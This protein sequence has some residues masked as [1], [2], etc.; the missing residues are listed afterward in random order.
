MQEE[1]NQKLISYTVRAGKLTGKSLLKVLSFTAKNVKKVYDNRT[2]QN[3]KS[4]SKKSS[5]LSKIDIEE[6]ALKN[7]DLRAFKEIAKSYGVKFAITQDKEKESYTFFFDSSKAEVFQSVYEKYR[8]YLKKKEM[9][10]EDKRIDIDKLIEEYKLK[11]TRKLEETKEMVKE[12]I[13]KLR[14]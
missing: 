12:R 14:R 6:L 1:V 7:E 11:K 9:S 8:D 10:K 13:K 4:L 2:M 5:S 3:L